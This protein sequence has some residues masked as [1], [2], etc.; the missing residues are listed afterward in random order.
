MIKL[1]MIRLPSSVNVEESF[2]EACLVAGFFMFARGLWLM[3][4]PGMWLGCGLALIWC[5]LPPRRE[6]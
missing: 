3:Y 4:P 5:G 1:P 6:R 2:R